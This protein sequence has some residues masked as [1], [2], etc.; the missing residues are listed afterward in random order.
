MVKR[1]KS[2][3]F[4]YFLAFLVVVSSMGGCGTWDK[5]YYK[6]QP[7]FND[8]AAA[9]TAVTEVKTDD[10][11]VEKVT[12]KPEFKD[13]T[14]DSDKIIYVNG[15]KVQVKDGVINFVDLK[16][17]IPTEDIRV[18]DADVIGFSSDIQ[19]ALRR[20]MDRARRVRLGSGSIQ[21]IAA[22]TGATLGLMTGDVATAAV[23]AAVSAVMPEFQHIFKLK[24][25]LKHTNK[26]WN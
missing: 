23:F 25:G 19:K 15:L 9:R 17:S 18:S 11:G 24:R 13:K 8:R 12:L 7:T 2:S 10:K 1:V 22:A 16:V 3:K 20:R 6:F 4:V 14:K 26:G 21:V 5:K